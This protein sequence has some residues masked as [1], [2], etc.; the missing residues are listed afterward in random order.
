MHRTVSQDNR[1]IGCLFVVMGIVNFVF[2][3]AVKVA[4]VTALLEV[5]WVMLVPRLLPGKGGQLLPFDVA[6]PVAAV[7]VVTALVLLTRFKLITLVFK[8]PS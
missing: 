7:A 2:N 3:L 5:C 8:R 4:A 1:W 6:L